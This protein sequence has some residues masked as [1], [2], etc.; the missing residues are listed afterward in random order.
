MASCRQLT[1][2][3][4]FAPRRVKATVLTP[5]RFIPKRPRASGRGHRSSQ[6]DGESPCSAAYLSL[7][8]EMHACHRKRHLNTREG[9]TSQPMGVI[10]S[11][12]GREQS[13]GPRSGGTG[14]HWAGGA[15]PSAVGTAP[16]GLS[17]KGQPAANRILH[18]A[19]CTRTG[20]PR[21]QTS[22]WTLRSPFSAVQGGGWASRSARLPPSPRVQAQ[23]LKLL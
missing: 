3:R 19:P 7:A 16:R 12:G 23:Q 8:I 4:A 10:S 17:G 2:S 1:P 5:V 11:P 18:R 15:G 14:S 9:L 21:S 20:R 22:P 13:R 6:Q